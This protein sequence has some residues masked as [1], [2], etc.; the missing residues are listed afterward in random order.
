MIF[1]P[2]NNWGREIQIS[3]PDSPHRKLDKRVSEPYNLFVLLYYK[4]V[5]RQ[6]NIH[7]LREIINKI[8]NKPEMQGVSTPSPISMEEPSMVT[9]KRKNLAKWL[10][11]SLN[12]SHDALF[13]RLFGNSS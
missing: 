4:L 7:S 12:L 11:S 9:N 3:K 5:S 8:I 2:Y 1:F 13:R 6:A 10:F